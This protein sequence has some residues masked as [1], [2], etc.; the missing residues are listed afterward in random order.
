MATLPTQPTRA[1][2]A[3]LAELL[4][5]TIPRTR[6]SRSRSTGQTGLLEKTFIRL[7]PRPETTSPAPS[8]NTARG[9]WNYRHRYVK[10]A[11]FRPLTREA[12]MDHLAE[13]A[14][15]ALRNAR[16]RVI[17]KVSRKRSLDPSVKHAWIR[18]FATAFDELEAAAPA[19]IEANS[20]G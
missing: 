4:S 10:P 18:D 1:P 20:Y 7:K 15:N 14:W 11:P 8:K 17:E 13:E 2:L 9:P 5:P 19:G 16:Q 6:F 3:T 12:A